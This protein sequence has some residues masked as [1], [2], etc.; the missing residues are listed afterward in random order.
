MGDVRR[1]A[2]LR[3]KGRVLWD[4]V[5]AVYD[6]SDAELAL[7]GE[8][9][10]TLDQLEALDRQVAHDGLMVTG[11]MGQQRLHPALT[12]QR[13]LRLVLGRLLAQLALPD[14][15]GQVIPS[16]TS[17]RAREAAMHRWGHRGPA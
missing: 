15:E 14:E 1:P 4:A 17:L 5:T 11:S 6:L 16:A 13:G 7:L 2:R 9:C 3:A 12:E 8:A 10:R